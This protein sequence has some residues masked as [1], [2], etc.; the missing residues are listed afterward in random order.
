V[1]KR[2]FVVA[3]LDGGGGEASSAGKV[4]RSC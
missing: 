1:E 2:E 3:G 4:G